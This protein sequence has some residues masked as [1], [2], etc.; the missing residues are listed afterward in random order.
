MHWLGWIVAL[1]AFVEGGWLA[2]DGGHALVTGD[3][4]TPSSGT[5]AGKFG[6]WSKLVLAVGLEPRSTSMKAIHLALGTI[7]IAMIICFVL[8]LPWAW[9][10][11]LVCAI[12][13]LWYLPFGTL[14]SIIQIVLLLLPTLRN[15]V[16]VSGS[17]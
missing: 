15:P 13:G 14:L 12:T 1:L 10:A 16:V 5:Y 17:L 11:M 3:Y 6:P 9:T 8:R 4:V 2:F 7:W